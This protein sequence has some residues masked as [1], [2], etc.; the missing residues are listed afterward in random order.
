MSISPWAMLMMPIRPNVTASP[1]LMISSTA[2]RLMPLN[3]YPTML[4]WA[5][6]RSMSWSAVRAA[7]RT[8]GSVS[9]AS[10]AWSCGTAASEA[11]RPSCLTAPSRSAGSGARRR[12]LASAS[13]RAARTSRF[14]SPSIAR[15]S[16]G[17]AEGSPEVPSLKAADS[18]I[19][20]P[21]RGAR[22]PRRRRARSAPTPPR[23]RRR[24]RALRL[25]R[26][27]HPLA[28]DHVEG[29]LAAVA[30]VAVATG[31][32]HLAPRRG[33]HPR[34][35]L[36]DHVELTVLP[37]LADVDRLP[38]VVVLLVHL[39]LAHRAR[40]LE[41]LERLEHLLDVGGLRLLDRLRPEVDVDVRVHHRVV[42]DALLVRDAVT[43]APLL[44]RLHPLEVVGRLER[45]EVVP[46]GEVPDE[47]LDVERLQLDLGEA[48]RH[49]RRLVGSHT[50]VGE[51]LEEGHVAVAVD[52]VDDGRVARRPEALD[53]ADDRLVVLV[54]ERCVL[55]RD[56]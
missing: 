12:S 3:R 5:T 25:V 36:P 39:V 56:P 21:A 24:A 48:V 28:A 6:N 42:G 19:P 16:T 26:Q 32:R 33:S 45:H 8:A 20:D 27:P 35:G 43:L 13:S 2:A 53:L 52:R 7:A 18:P 50:L 47:R 38:R 10:S 30:P 31:V 14:V 4:R 55:L 54:V 9:S 37:D 49:G 44:V 17:I 34:L 40:D 41:T 1:R 22:G 23:G 46:G 11:R 51:L 15:A 29:A